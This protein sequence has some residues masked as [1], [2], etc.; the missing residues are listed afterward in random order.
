[1]RN[2]LNPF[3]SQAKQK[4]PARWLAP[5]ENRWGLVVLDCTQNACT[6]MSTSKSIEIVKKYHD[7]RNSTGEELRNRVFNP[8]LSVSCSL[9]YNVA[10]RAPDGPVFK[11]HVMEE[12]WDIYLYGD[13]L[14][15]CR[16]WGGELTY[17]A[18][19]ECQPPALRVPMIETSQKSAEKIAV[20]DVD[21]LIKSHVLGAKAL[22]PLP[23]DMG[24]DTEKL[25][26]FSFAAWGRMGLYG[27]FEETIGTP[28]YWE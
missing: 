10:Q 28:C 4:I 15:F 27:T 9:A 24:R 25:A 14:Y 18:A 21:F 26:L 12:K 1:M 8:T 16:S 7:L 23:R 3:H 22:H 20:R 2:W 11:S 17:R 19:V 13:H 5:S 6:M